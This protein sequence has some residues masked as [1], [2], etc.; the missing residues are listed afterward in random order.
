MS[1]E[2]D[3]VIDAL[4]SL[5][6]VGLL[7]YNGVKD[8]NVINASMAT[9]SALTGVAKAKAKESKSK[10]DKKKKGK[11]KDEKEESESDSSDNDSSSDED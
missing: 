8:P 9:S 3:N 11:K 4:G 2:T 6:T 7:S 5:A 10:S 1:D